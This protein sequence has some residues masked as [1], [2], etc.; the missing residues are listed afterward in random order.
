MPLYVVL[1]AACLT[2]PSWQLVKMEIQRAIIM[3]QALLDL[4][5]RWYYTTINIMTQCL[6]KYYCILSNMRAIVPRCCLV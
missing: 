4:M 6:I 5:H 1:I 2:Y 3:Y